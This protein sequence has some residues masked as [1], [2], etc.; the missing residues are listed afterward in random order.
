[1]SMCF[2]KP[3]N[4]TNENNNRF[5]V[6]KRCLAMLLLA[7]DTWHKLKSISALDIKLMKIHVLNTCASMRS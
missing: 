2:R 1:M 4:E 5:N 6:C 7:S 3:D